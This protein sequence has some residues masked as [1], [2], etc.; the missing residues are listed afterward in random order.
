MIKDDLLCP[1]LGCFIGPLAAVRGAWRVALAWARF[2][3]P[4]GTDAASGHWQGSEKF[5]L[6]PLQAAGEVLGGVKSYAI[7]G[8]R[9]AACVAEQMQNF[10]L[11]ATNLSAP[12]CRQLMSETT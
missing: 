11:I 5:W 3:W 9:G 2:H 8:L 12:K 10:L 6:G 4:W 1:D 7:T